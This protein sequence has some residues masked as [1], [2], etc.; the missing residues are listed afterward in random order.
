MNAKCGIRFFNGSEVRL[1]LNGRQEPRLPKIG[2]TSWCFFPENGQRI[3]KNQLL[4]IT[5]DPEEGLVRML[6]GPEF[7]GIG[8]E[9]AKE[10][11]G[12][13]CEHVLVALQDDSVDLKETFSISEK[14]EMSLREG[15]DEGRETRYLKLLLLH[16]GL[17][18]ASV[19]FVLDNLGSEIIEILNS[20]PFSLIGQVPRITFEEIRFIVARLNLDVDAKEKIV[21]G[22]HFCL[23]RIE[24]QRGHTA[25]PL[26]R[27]RRDLG[28]QF[29]IKDEDF[30]AAL[31]MK[32]NQLVLADT[33]NAPFIQ[34]SKAF[35][36]DH[37]IV[38]RITVILQN[39]AKHEIADIDLDDSSVSGGAKLSEEQISVLKLALKSSLSVI[40]GGP[41]TGKTSIVLALLKAF[42]AQGQKIHICAPTG[43]AAKRL[44]ETPGMK[45]YQPSTIHMML[46]R[47]PK[48]I[49]VL[50]IDEASMIDADLM[51]LVC[52]VLDQDSKLI[53]I[54]DV[55]QL[56]PVQSGQVFK[57]LIGSNKI[58]VG[59]LTK[60]FR[61]QSGSDII[62][63]AQSV[64]SGE[65]PKSGDGKTSKDFS[66]LDEVN[67]SR[68]EQ[69]IVDLYLRKLPR[70]LN[71]DPI[72][73]IQILS[74]MRKGLLGIENLNEKIQ[75]VLYRGRKP[76]IERKF[77]PDL[78][79]GDKVI[80]TKN[81]YEKG[82]MNGDTGFI[83]GKKGDDFKLIFDGRRV[84]YSLEDLNSVQL[85]YAISI[86][87]SQ[88]SEY[89]A[90]IVPISKQHQ[91]MLGR[92]L[93]YTAITRGRERVVV[94][95]DKG[96][97]SYGIGAEWKE[98]RYSLLGHWISAA[99]TD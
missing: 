38:S 61:Q 44:S 29:E 66:F 28:A 27:I 63:A 62:S 98:F 21:S 41:G 72:K 91:H 54:G 57:D 8:E 83:A 18:D 53:L 49:E 59:R 51:A 87:K 69:L 32:N 1:F 36:R 35:E 26:N 65:F 52:E 47:E 67:D 60:I 42:E 74:P 56:P 39:S 43:R 45:K 95:G 81:N 17:T 85:A 23:H 82:V 93:I 37:E 34:T 9:T 90:V 80:Q 70:Q 58:P 75:S 77:G 64:L 12:C 11:V 30:N 99:L 89:P 76:L 84:D 79:R 73:D 24:M 78:Y 5:E 14:I 16:L 19:N 92:N 40:T 46:A 15:W 33:D 97:F 22:I 94:A 6:S 88:G 20:R 48:S 7:D 13:G 96:T 10:I 50:V 4:D 31:K 71:L 55:D 86:H 25:A 2:A 68:L 3:S